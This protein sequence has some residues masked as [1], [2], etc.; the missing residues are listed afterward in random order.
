MFMR[1]RAKLGGKIKQTHPVKDF[2]WKELPLDFWR[3]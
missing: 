2:K 1:I 3:L